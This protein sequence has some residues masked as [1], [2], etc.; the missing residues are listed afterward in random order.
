MTG[1]G[2][3]TSLSNQVEDCWQRILAG[4]SGIHEIK[5]VDNS[6]LKV[7]IGGDVYDFDPASKIGQRESKKIDRFSQFAM[8]CGADAV[9]SEFWI[10]CN[11]LVSGEH[12][13]AI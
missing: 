7:K 12:P 11:V 13:L 3:I 2:I 8:V 5:I 1:W 10:V 9:T 6:D 4:E